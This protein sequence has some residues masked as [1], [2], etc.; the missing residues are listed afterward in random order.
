MGGWLAK[1]DVAKEAAFARDGAAKMHGQA[2]GM[3]PGAV[4]AI[5]I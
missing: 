1:A 5:G 3:L 2:I 4:N